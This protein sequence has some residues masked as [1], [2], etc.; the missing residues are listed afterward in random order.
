M[1]RM[2]DRYQ[3]L[4]ART[5]NDKLLPSEQLSNYA[6]GLAG[7]TGEL[8]DLFKKVLYHGHPLDRNAIKDEAGDALWY[9]AM[10][11]RKVGIS[12]EDVARENIG[13]LRVRYPN[14]FSE[15]DSLNRKE[16]R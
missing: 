12:F 16:S 8:V 4:A 15:N 11:L 9:L 7:E 6:L 10:L 2:F 5:E 3:E 13:K 1:D 14:G